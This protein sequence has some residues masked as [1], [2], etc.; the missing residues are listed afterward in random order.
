MNE[1]SLPVNSAGRHP[2]SIILFLL[3]TF[4]VLGVDLLTKSMA[5]EHVAGRPVKLS[6]NTTGDP[7]LIP[8]HKPIDLIPG[9]LSLRLTTNTG[10]VFG[11]GK[12]AQSL[13]VI[14]SLVAVGVI[15]RVFWT[16]SARA[17]CLHVALGLV[18]AGAL[19]NLHDRIRFNAVRDLLWLFPET[20]LWPWIFN[21]ADAVLLVGVATMI[22]VM[23][24]SD[25]KR[26]AEPE[27][28]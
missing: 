24:W 22:L 21:V 18:L 26:P 9:V 27:D 16:S 28:S 10:A 15:G 20:G 7:V 1:K 3:V 5:F 25:R 14:A 2:Q 4:S 13:F 17:W 12:G 6:R 19:G 8:Y 23:W 11:L